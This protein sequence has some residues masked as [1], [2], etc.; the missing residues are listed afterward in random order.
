MARTSTALTERVGVQEVNLIFTKRLKWFFREQTISDFGVDAEVEIVDEEG[1]PTGQLIALQVKSGTSF[2]QHKDAEGYTF[3]GEPRH[4]DEPPRDCRRPQLLRGR[5]YY[6][7]DD[8][9]VCTGGS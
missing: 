9:Q 3:Y 4:L 6:E 2:F 5:V 8:E 7:Q 1:E